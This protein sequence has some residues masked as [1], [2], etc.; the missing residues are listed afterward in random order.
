MKRFAKRLHAAERTIHQGFGAVGCGRQGESMGVAVEARMG[1]KP[2]NVAAFV[3]LD[4]KLGR[5]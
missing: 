3:G 2:G 4:L 1:E 5:L